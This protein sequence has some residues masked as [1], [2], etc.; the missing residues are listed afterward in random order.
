MTYARAGAH[1]GLVA[2]RESLLRELEKEWTGRGARVEVY[3]GDVADTDFMARSA[4][5]FVAAAGGV[6]LVLANAGVAIAHRVLE[7]ESRDIAWL[8]SV[9]AIG[10]TNTVVPF[11]PA[12]LKQG[13]GV[14]C[15]VSSSA[16]HRPLPGRAAYSASK[17]C[18][19][20]FMTSLRMDLHG[21]GV[22][23]M[24][25]CPGFVHTPL[26][27]GQKGMMFA[28]DVPRAVEYMV[29]AIESRKR[30]YTYPW[31]MKLLKEVMARVPESVIRRLAPPPR[32]SSSS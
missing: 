7:G 23:A 3:A 12:M 31:Q 22:H 27:E 14:L 21:T 4:Q 17:A 25:L 15:A 11:I 18:V 13:S 24:T 32:T 16:G 9:N 19:T 26:T 6:D 2:R 1:L 20:S 8:M 30:T 10:V 29:G 28:I 5:A